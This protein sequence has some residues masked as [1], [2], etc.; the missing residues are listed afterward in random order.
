MYS[1]RARLD[2]GIRSAANKN[3]GRLF[4]GLSIEA[5]GKS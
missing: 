3:Q 5:E 2:V 1:A 4:G